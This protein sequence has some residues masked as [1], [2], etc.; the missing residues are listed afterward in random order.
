MFFLDQQ[1]TLSNDNDCVF[2]KYSFIVEYLDFSKRGAHFRNQ[3][4]YHFKCLDF[5][6]EI[7][8]IFGPTRITPCSDVCQNVLFY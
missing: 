8:E 6:R 2:N 5:I 3:H 1:Y 7:V 4:K